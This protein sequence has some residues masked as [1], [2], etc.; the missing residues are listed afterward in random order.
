MHGDAR[1][2]RGAAVVIERQPRGRIVEVNAHVAGQRLSAASAVQAQDAVIGDVDGAVER[3]AVDDL[4]ARIGHAH[5]QGSVERD[6]VQEVD[7]AVTSCEL[8]AQ[9]RTQ[10]AAGHVDAVQSD[11]TI[12]DGVE[13]PAGV[14][15]RPA[16]E[17]KSAARPVDT[18][19]PN[20]RAAT[21]DAE[22]RSTVNQQR[23]RAGP[24][25]QRIDRVAAGVVRNCI[26][27]GHTDGDIGRGIRKRGKPV[28]GRAPQAVA[29]VAS[30]ADGSGKS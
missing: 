2:Q 8:S 12:V 11:N 18:N 27:A 28:A 15:E 3:G 21:T 20:I 22:C 14:G 19:G 5:V 25:R 16:V 13:R 26:H 4:F 7:V 17:S 23:V 29:G 30:P 9:A 1:T 10:D 24:Y 6:V